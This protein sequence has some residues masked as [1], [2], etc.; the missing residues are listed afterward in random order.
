MT[1]PKINGTPRTPS[2][3]AQPQMAPG[4]ARDRVGPVLEADGDLVEA[5]VSAIRDNHPDAAVIDRGGYLRVLVPG[6]CVVQRAAVERALGRPFRLPG[7]L[8]LV[9]PSF[10]GAIEIT[11]DEVVWA[12]RSEGAP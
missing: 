11:D 12:W 8:E 9:M 3:Q 2:P 6:R 5:I 4:D 7:D 10:K 1:E